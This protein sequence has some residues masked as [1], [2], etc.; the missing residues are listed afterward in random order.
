MGRPGGDAFPAARLAQPRSL[1]RRLPRH[2]TV[3]GYLFLLPWLIGFVL[4]TAGP[5]VAS[6]VLSLTEWKL[7]GAPQFVGLRNY[8]DMLTD[9]PRFWKSLGNT[10]YYVVAHVPLTMVIAFV[11]A[12]LLNQPI[13][14]QALYR[15]IYYLPAVTT[16]VATA[17]LWT[18]LFNQ[19]FGLINGALGLVGVPPIPWLSSTRWAMPALILMSLWSFGPTM[20]IYL[21]GLQGIPLHLYEAAEVDGANSWQ[22]VRNVTIPMMSPT[23]LFTA[24]M[25]IIN[26]FQVFTVAYVMTAGGPADATMFYVLH[27]FYNAFRY[28]QMGYAS[29]LAWTLFLIVLAFTVVQ[30]RFAR[31]WVYY[32]AETPERPT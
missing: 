21:A 31:R 28:F 6:L 23:I 1:R 9:D 17:I 26:S 3:V 2:E 18:W 30:L 24:V 15:T 5:F 29:A 19:D 13:R 27:V 25:G 16:G 22:R 14:G 20:V 11:M 4:F 32:E 12:L 10:A 7:I 8:S